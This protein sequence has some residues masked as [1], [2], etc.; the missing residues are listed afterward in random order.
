MGV[1]EELSKAISTGRV[2]IGTDRSLKALKRGG[3][4]LVVAANNCPQ[5]TLD[6]LEHYASLSGTKFHI[7]NNNSRELGL[8]CGKP[9]T[10]NVVAIVDPGSSNVLSAVE[11]R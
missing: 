10:V 8:V 5:E 3:V 6:D 7:F 2:I 4:K 11:N 9:F 1:S